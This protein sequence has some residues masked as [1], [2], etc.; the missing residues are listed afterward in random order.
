MTEIKKGDIKIIQLS[1]VIL[2]LNVLLKQV[3]RVIF[4][5]NQERHFTYKFDF[6][7][8]VNFKE[9]I[10]ILNNLKSEITQKIKTVIKT[11]VENLKK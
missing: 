1:N 6:T 11:F 10:K 9:D 5:M 7:Y 3:D 8:K 2:H 4:M